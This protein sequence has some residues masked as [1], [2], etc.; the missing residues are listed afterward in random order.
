ME[1]ISLVRKNC[2]MESHRGLHM[3]SG[4]T[5][6]PWAFQ[7]TMFFLRDPGRLDGTL[8]ASATFQI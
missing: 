1:M 3:F 4:K 5:F 8:V 6:F 2:R 7:Q